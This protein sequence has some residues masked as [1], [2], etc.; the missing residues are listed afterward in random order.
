MKSVVA[1]K[2]NPNINEGKSKTS[3]PLSP[4]KLEKLFSKLILSGIEELS[5]EEQKEVKDLISEFGSL[6]VLDDVD[7]EEPLW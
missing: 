1:D 4:E 6:F 5:K 3:L 2:G 7:M